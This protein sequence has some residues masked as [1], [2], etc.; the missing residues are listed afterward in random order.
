M[1]LENWKRPVRPVS[2]ALDYLSGRRGDGR[3]TFDGLLPPTTIEFHQTMANCRGHDGF[4]R[5]L[6]RVPVIDI[7]SDRA[8]VL[9]HELAH[10]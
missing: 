7:C 8:Y 6:D 10:A 5:Y 2:R 3:S 1:K 4:I 9:P